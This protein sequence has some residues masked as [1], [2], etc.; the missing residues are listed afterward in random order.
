MALM[1]E[2]SLV[3]SRTREFEG[4]SS[5]PP[6]TLANQL[7]SGMRLDPGRQGI[8]RHQWFDTFDWRLFEAGFILELATWDQGQ[9]AQVRLSTPSNGAV[10]TADAGAP[11][12]E[13]AE[14]RRSLALAALV[15]S[16]PI[17]TQ[18]EPIVGVRTLLP[19]ATAT[20]RSTTYRIL[21]GDSK[22]VA[23]LIV[24]EPFLSQPEERMPA[25]RVSVDPVRGYEV[26]AGKLARRLSLAPG[27]RASHTR[28]L[29]AALAAAGRTPGDYS[30][31]FEV[32]LEPTMPSVSALRSILA[33]LE[34]AAVA[35]I[36][37]VLADLDTEFLH[38][39]RVAV[40]R[41][42]SALKLLGDALPGAE[43][44]ALAVDLK[45]MGDLTTPTRDLD[46][47][48]LQL[49]APGDVP[50]CSDL[51][52]FRSFLQQQRRLAQRSLARG[53]RSRR[54]AVALEGWR[55]LAR[56]RSEVPYPGDSPMAGT[57]IGQVAAVRIHRA[58]QRC[59]RVGG[60]ITAD[61]PATDLHSLRKRCKE[62]RYL[63]EFFSSLLARPPYRAVTDQLKAL[64]DCLGEFQDTQVQGAEMQ[65]FAEAMLAAG[66]AQAATLL[67]MGRA[68]EQLLTRQRQARDL[69][70]IRFAHFANRA[71]RGQ[72]A[73]LDPFP[74]GQRAD[75]DQL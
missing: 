68:T 33:R 45:W 38:D 64:Q 5:L 29:M 27:L 20:A 41:A 21:N 60:M 70:T 47:Y 35:N 53:L 24:E 58:Y 25:T 17:R 6:A 19:V 36:P 12:I 3:P 62:L 43:G 32:A 8:L 26:E 52:P 2:R 59:V 66:S 63:L 49:T 9:P 61:S 46:V 56:P 11:P 44:R 13:G 51:F 75:Q 34:A 57:P 69:F 16:G 31:R 54:W 73:R 55:S 40:R 15:P 18:L 65:E 7:G 10:R 28:P 23:R 50:I 71:T 48:L 74:P 4:D 30:G 22:T 1:S 42:R 72:V 39:L 37:G 14:R 67:A